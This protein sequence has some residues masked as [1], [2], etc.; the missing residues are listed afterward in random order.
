M[1]AGA[2]ARP[3]A[4]TPE[5]PTVTGT[6]IG[7]PAYMAP[8][9]AAGNLRE[10]GPLT[11]VY[12]LGTILY[13]LL[14]GQPPFSSRVGCQ[15]LQDVQYRE[16]PRPRTLNPRADADL[17][18]ICLKCM[19]K[20]P[21]NRYSSAEA[22]ADDLAR[23]LRGKPTRVRPFLPWHTRLRRSA[24]RHPIVS[25]VL[26]L[27]ALAGLST[28][29]AAYLENRD[30]W[31][32]EASLRQGCP[33]TLIEE[34]GPPTWY[35]WRTIDGDPIVVVQAPL[36]EFSIPSGARGRSKETT[37][38]RIWWGRSIAIRRA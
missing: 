31:P 11:D 19:E 22:L 15:T 10:V 20:K 8:E 1:L 7:T 35:R 5:S 26:L 6:T 12:A 37:N 13:E 21:A 28:R 4:V 25:T 23:W 14:T 18:A 34:T 2:G 3:E 38:P 30:V 24:R 9:Q 29:V 17:E 32:I 33:V 36:E 27:A 16:P